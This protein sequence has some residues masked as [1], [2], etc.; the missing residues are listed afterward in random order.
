MENPN[1]LDMDYSLFSAIQKILENPNTMQSFLEVLPPDCTSENVLISMEIDSRSYNMTPAK[2][3]L[4]ILGTKGFRISHLIEWFQAIGLEKALLL[5]KKEEPL[6]IIYHPQKEVE[7][8]EGSELLL[9]CHAVSYPPPEY[10]WYKDDKELLLQVD[11]VLIKKPISLE[12]GGVYVCLVTKWDSNKNT[13][14]WLY[15]EFS[16]VKVIP[17][18]DLH[19]ISSLGQEPNSSMHFSI[20]NKEIT[21]SHYLL[22]SDR[23][24]SPVFQN[25]SDCQPKLVCSPQTILSPHKDCI[26]IIKHPYVAGKVAPGMSL[27]LNCEA[28]CNSH[29]EYQWFKNGRAL[30]GE[31]FSQLVLNYLYPDPNTGERKWDYQCE[32]FNEFDRV[33]SHIVTVELDEANDTTPYIATQKYAFLVANDR[34]DHLEHLQKP[35]AD[36]KDLADILSSLGFQ[37]FASRNLNL[38]EMRNAFAF[39]CQTLRPGSYALFFFAGHGFELYG[40]TYLQPVDSSDG[41]Q[42]LESM[43]SEYILQCMQERN[44]AMNVLII[45]AC[46]KLPLNFSEKSQGPLL[47]GKIFQAKMKNNTIYGYSTSFLCASHESDEET[48]SVFVRHLKNFLRLEKCIQD[49]LIMVQN[50]FAKDPIAR[51]V[52]FPVIKSTLAER[53]KLSDPIQDSSTS[54]ELFDMVHW[55]DIKRESVSRIIEI[56]RIKAVIRVEFHHHM[57]VFCNGMDV[58]VYLHVE[59]NAEM[60]I[61]HDM[62]I[63]ISFISPVLH[64]VPTDGVALKNVDLLIGKRNFLF[65]K[66]I[67]NVQKINTGSLKCSI[68]LKF[69]LKNIVKS[70]EFNADVAKISQLQLSLNH[71]AASNVEELS[72]DTKQDFNQITT[73]NQHIAN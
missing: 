34:Y 29:L 59:P 52:Q 30:Q 47:P 40:Q 6:T 8:N 35:A 61:L 26:T 36:V 15:S 20:L 13:Y 17:A 32:V 19:A 4:R 71:L 72:S 44:P 9:T 25:N 41:S 31:S 73:N 38:A 54:F 11:P 21:P 39:F 27:C 48:N 62:E 58:Y 70:I 46:R 28:I 66:D 16:N 53:R 14:E 51:N 68:S 57:E 2:V 60:L 67:L 55:C 1:I 42:I 50:D 5:L 10:Q 63:N 18:D 33:F 37:I 3:L 65:K 45:D 64:V 69:C 24:A 7:V 56:P 49:I 12:D 23:T 22:K 43:C